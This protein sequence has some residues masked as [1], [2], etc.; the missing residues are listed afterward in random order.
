MAFSLPVLS[1]VTSSLSPES[2]AIISHISFHPRT[3][4]SLDIA[5]GIF[6]QLVWAAAPE[7]KSFLILHMP[8]ES[9]IR[10]QLQKAAAERR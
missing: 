9:H 8:L 10:G 4:L 6:A 2:Q 1:T 5:F 7:L 3:F